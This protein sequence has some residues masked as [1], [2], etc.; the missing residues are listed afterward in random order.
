MGDCVSNYWNYGHLVLSTYDDFGISVVYSAQPPLSKSQT[1]EELDMEIGDMK[2]D[3]LSGKPLITYLRYNFLI[4]KDTLNDLKLDGDKL[5]KLGYDKKF[6]DEGARNI[7]DMARAKNREILYEI[8]VEA[9]SSINE[10]H[11]SKF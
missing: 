10:E 9:S 3:V 1:A 11:F 8:G 5:N 6:D 7:V 2:D 4:N